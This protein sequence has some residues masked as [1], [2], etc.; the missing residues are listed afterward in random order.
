MSYMMHHLII[1]ANLEVEIIVH[2]DTT[3]PCYNLY[4]EFSLII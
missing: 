1:D 4:T 2:I 3:T